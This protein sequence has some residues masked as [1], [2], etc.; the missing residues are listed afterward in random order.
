MVTKQG[1]R[2]L[3]AGVGAVWRLCAP[4]RAGQDQGSPASPPRSGGPGR[5]LTP[6]ASR[7]ASGRPARADPLRPRALF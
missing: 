7:S 2:A 5:A 3:L 1:S 4:R 6:A